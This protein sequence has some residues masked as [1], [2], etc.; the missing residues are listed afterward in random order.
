MN[1]YFNEFP[2]NNPAYMVKRI[3]AKYIRDRA[4]I[5]FSGRLVE[6]GCGSKNKSLLVK[7]FVKE[8]IGLDILESRHDQSNID[9][10]ADA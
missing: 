7:T 6:I 5:F 10:Y 1:S 9:I 4:S 2:I 3:G 8:H